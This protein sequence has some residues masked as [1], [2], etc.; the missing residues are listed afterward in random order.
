MKGGWHR[1]HWEPSK[2]IYPAYGQPPLGFYFTLL[3]LR[4]W[5]GVHVICEDLQNPVCPVLQQAAVVKHL[6]MKVSIGLPLHKVVVA[7]AC[8]THVANAFGSMGSVWG[9]SPRLQ[10]RYGFTSPA[11]DAASCPNCLSH[12]LVL[13]GTDNYFQFRQVPGPATPHDW[14]NTGQERAQMLSPHPI[15]VVVCHAHRSFPNTTQ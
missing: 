11:P 1:G 14:H 5:A 15:H 6:K 10:H 12:E 4:R 2:H 9:F 13:V 3:N 8:A 7:M